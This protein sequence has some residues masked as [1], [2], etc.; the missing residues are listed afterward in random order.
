MRVDWIGIGGVQVASWAELEDAKPATSN[1]A[2]T[3][4]HNIGCIWH[5][6]LLAYFCRRRLRDLSTRGVA[7][8][9]LGQKL[10]L[11]KKLANDRYGIYGRPGLSGGL[12]RVECGGQ[13]VMCF[14]KAAPANSADCLATLRD[15]PVDGRFGSVSCNPDGP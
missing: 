8:S 5:S 2:A 14:R 1:V 10:P 11:V 12:K 3:A 7:M 4:V 13:E 9:A 6:R 15:H